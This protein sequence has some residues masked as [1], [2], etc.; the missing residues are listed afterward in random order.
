MA[1]E[2]LEAQFGMGARVAGVDEAVPTRSI[3]LL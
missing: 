3:D 1:Y 2:D